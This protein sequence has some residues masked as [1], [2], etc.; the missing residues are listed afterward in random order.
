M[1]RVK[2]CTRF[3]ASSCF[4]RSAYRPYGNVFCSYWNIRFK[5]AHC[6]FECGLNYFPETSIT[7]QVP[8][9]LSR[10]LS[11]MSVT[12]RL[13]FHFPVL[14]LSYSLFLPITSPFIPWIS[15]Q[16]VANRL[17]YPF[18]HCKALGVMYVFLHCAHVNVIS[19]FRLSWRNMS[20]RSDLK[21]VPGSTI[22]TSLKP[23]KLLYQ[24]F[25]VNW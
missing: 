15:P 16:F 11:Y 10:D 6:D 5:S 13:W 24:A 23:F 8:R 2:F 3:K 17:Y 21:V 20:W 18:Q 14:F 25:I 4:A 22:K 19:R 7:F 9:L 1:V 12:C